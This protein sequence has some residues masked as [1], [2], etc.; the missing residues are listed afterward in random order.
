MILKFKKQI[1]LL[2]AG[3]FSMVLAACYG[4][5]VD[6][7]YQKTVR[8]VNEKNEAIPGLQVQLTNNGNRILEEVTGADGTINY[9][10]LSEN[11]EN[12]Y[13]VIINDIDGE[14]NGGFFETKVVDIVDSLNYYE[15]NM[16]NE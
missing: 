14:E 1:T 4:M 7:E 11:F 9:S 5:P 13:K 3:S 16:N 8:T 6:M 15:V 12:D 10:D 2:F